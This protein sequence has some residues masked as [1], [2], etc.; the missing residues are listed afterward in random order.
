M[1]SFSPHLSM[2]CFCFLSSILLKLSI[3]PYFLELNSIFLSLCVPLCVALSLYVCIV[4]NL[5]IY[6]HML[7]V[8]VYVM[9]L[10]V[11]FATNLFVACGIYVCLS[12][13]RFVFPLNCL[14]RC[15]FSFVYCCT[16]VLELFHDSFIV[17]M[18]FLLLVR[19]VSRSL[20]LF[21][22]LLLR[23]SVCCSVATDSF[24]LSMEAGNLKLPRRLGWCP[25]A[26]LSPQ[27]LSKTNKHATTNAHTYTSI[28]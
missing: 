23:V 14:L 22:S 10:S 1:L 28:S 9:S 2:H 19:S 27:R 8:V 18:L 24:L 11:V 25:L 7:I 17:F 13:L 20:F 3:I 15:L 21:A 12:S 16:Y 6:I 4:L 5:F 26:A